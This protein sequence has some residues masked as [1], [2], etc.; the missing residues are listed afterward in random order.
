MLLRFSYMYVFVSCVYL[1]P[2]EVRRVGTGAT[3]SLSYYVDIGD[4]AEQQSSAPAE[5]VPNHRAT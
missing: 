2:T 4:Q 3:V 5:C 1:V